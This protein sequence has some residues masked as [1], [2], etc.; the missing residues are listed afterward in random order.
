MSPSNSF[1]RAMRAAWGTL[2]RGE[3]RTRPSR[4]PAQIV[5]D[6][7]GFDWLAGVWD[8]L[9]ARAGSPIQ[10]HLWARAYVETFD[11]F[12]RLNLVCVGPPANPVAIAPLVE[13][14]DLPPRLEML[15][16]RDLQE[17]VDFLYSDARALETLAAAVA[18]TRAPLR[19][20]RIPADSLFIGALRKAY[21]RRGWVRV[22]SGD[23]CPYIALHAGWAEPESQFDSDRRSDLR[24]ARRH[25][26]RMGAVE[27]EVHA[28]GPD[29]L[30]AM[31]DTAY[32]VEAAG[33]KGASGS[34][35]AQGS[36]HGTFYRRY[37]GEAARKGLLRLCFLRIGGVP[38]AMQIA[39]ECGG[40]FW[41]LK[42]GHDEKYSRCSPGSLLTLHTI[43]Y[44][45]TRGLRSYEFLGNEEAWTK[46][47]TDTS[48]TRVSVRAYPPG[49][50][51]LVA[52]VADVT[53]SAWRRLGRNSPL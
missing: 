31:L 21:G 17:P 22:L 27:C 51:G 42:I 30:G 34:A 40:R 41:L 36:A 9:A 8:S 2:A 50:R 7:N 32:Q 44:A 16:V 43:G 24:R 14:P 46:K 4:A 11:A 37:A 23:A 10:Q 15:G 45:A 12:S 35:L 18:K 29:E 52:L 25:A 3:P 47:W 49:A 53:R 20:D 48:R 39:L 33:W 38:V 28:P 6:L 5:Q 19:L 1:R 26:E 13:V